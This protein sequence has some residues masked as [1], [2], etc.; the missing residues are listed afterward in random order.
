MGA[1]DGVPWGAFLN[2]FPDLSPAGRSAPASLRMLRRGPSGLGVVAQ[3]GGGL[4][5]APPV[6]AARRGGA[7]GAVAREQGEEPGHA[8]RP[9]AR[10]RRTRHATVAP[11]FFVV[12]IRR[13][14]PA[15]F[16]GA[17]DGRQVGEKW[18][19]RAGFAAATY[20][21]AEAPPNPPTAVL[22]IP[23]FW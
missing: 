9:V 12:H 10:S 7:P 15:N 13:R 18:W 16:G 17:V 20:D 19:A 3:H 6:M 5:A 11:L 21:G 1:V 23:P 4:R 2:V 22:E 8:P 14:R